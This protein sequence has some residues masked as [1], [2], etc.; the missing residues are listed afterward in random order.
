MKEDSDEL[1][2][3]F[4]EEI[5]GSAGDNEY[6]YEFFHEIKEYCPETIFYGTDVGH[7]YNTT[8]LRYLRYLEENGLT[9]SEKYSLANENIQQGIAY[10]ESESSF[11]HSFKN[12]ALKYG[13]SINRLRH[14]SS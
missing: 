12:S 14:P 1:I 6:F 13:N 2:D 9:D 4:F 11:I 8:G 3:K 10:Y 7:L 5:K